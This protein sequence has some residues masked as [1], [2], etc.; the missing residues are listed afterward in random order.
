[1]LRSV[2]EAIRPGGLFV[3]L[4]PTIFAPADIGF[5]EERERWRLELVDLPQSRYCFDEYVGATQILY[6]PL[7]FRAILREAGFAALQ[8]E[9]FF[10]ESPAYA[11][12]P[13]VYGL[14]GTTP[15]C[16][17]SS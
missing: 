1:M 11:R 5:C 3:G 12:R 9:V 17:S 16:T 7:R 2:Y 13:R 15:C 6:T 8:M 4:F 10:C 14:E